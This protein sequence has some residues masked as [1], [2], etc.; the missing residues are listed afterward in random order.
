MSNI[1]IALS[2]LRDKL[3]SNKTDQPGNNAMMGTAGWTK[4]LK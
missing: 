2:M 1:S 3:F 4:S